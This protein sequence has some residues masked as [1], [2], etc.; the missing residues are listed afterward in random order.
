MDQISQ[1]LQTLESMSNEIIKSMD[2]KEPNARPSSSKRKDAA[3]SSTSMER[4][5]STFRHDSS[6][7]YI[8]LKF[9]SKD[10]ELGVR[11]S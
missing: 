5:L 8:K 2:P 1:T 7:D 9:I 3:S 10:R 4:R 11:N 6:F